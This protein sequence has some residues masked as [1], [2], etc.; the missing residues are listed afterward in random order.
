MTDSDDQLF[1]NFLKYFRRIDAA[2]SEDSVR[3]LYDAT[4]DRHG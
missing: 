1:S 2:A 3:A 4:D